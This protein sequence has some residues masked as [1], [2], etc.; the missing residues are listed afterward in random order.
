MAKYYIIEDN[1]HIHCGIDRIGF[2]KNNDGGLFA[3][4]L[5]SSYGT[6][7]EDDS[8]QHTIM[9]AQGMDEIRRLRD[10]LNSLNLGGE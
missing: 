1:V 5:Q 8:S 2:I 6:E 7:D 10:F 9:L 4:E 3:Q